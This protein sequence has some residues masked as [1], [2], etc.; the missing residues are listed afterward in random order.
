MLLCY[1]PIVV[2]IGGCTMRSLLLLGSLAFLAVHSAPAQTANSNL[3]GYVRGD[4]SAPLGGVE[5]SARDVA[6][7]QKRTTTSASS[8]YYYIG[9]MGPGQYELPPH[10]TGLQPD[11]EEDHPPIEAQH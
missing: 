1:S 2:L 10:R 3:R 4:Q 9:G 7:N 8:G 11:D 6:T 5:V